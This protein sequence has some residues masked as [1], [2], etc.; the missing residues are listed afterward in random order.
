MPR[1]IGALS[2][3]KTQ[4]IAAYIDAHLC[5]RCRTDK[6]AEVAGL[7]ASFFSRAFHKRFGLPVQQYVQKR[8]VLRAQDML[9][10]PAPLTEIALSCG[11]NDQSQLCRLFRR[12][13]GQ[14]PG[15]W[16]RTMSGQALRDALPLGQFLQTP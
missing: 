3:Y 2:P 14:P 8:R 10:T 16:R 11:L 15:A 7:S 12:W 13:V 6:L 9:M 5:E 1:V 4:R